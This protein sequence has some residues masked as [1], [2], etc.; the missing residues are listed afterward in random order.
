M[1]TRVFKSLLLGVFYF[2]ASAF[3]YSQLFGAFFVETESPYAR[4]R[5]SRDDVNAQ[6]GWG[7]AVE[8]S[9]RDV[10]ADRR[11][12]RTDAQAFDSSGV[13]DNPYMREEATPLRGRV[14]TFRAASDASSSD[15]RREPDPLRR[16]ERG[17]Q[18]Y[19]P[20]IAKIVGRSGLKTVEDGSQTVP[21]YYGT[22][23]YVAEYNS[24][25]I[26][27]TNWHVVNEAEE[28]IDVVFPSGA[29]PS[30]VIFRDETWDLAALIIPLPSD[31][32]PIPISFEGPAIG[33]TFWVG[34]YG[35]SSGL[36]EFQIRSGKLTNYVSLVD[37]A[38]EIVAELN[39]DVEIDPDDPYKLTEAP[40]KILS[41]QEAARIAQMNPTA[42]YETLS[43]DQGVRQGDSGGPIL[44]RYGELSGTLWGSDGKCTM[45]T[46]CVRVRAFLTEAIRCA[47][48]LYAQE[49]LDSSNKESS[50]SFFSTFI[51]PISCDASKRSQ[52]SAREALVAEGTFPISRRL[53]Y[54]AAADEEAEFFLRYTRESDAIKRAEFNADRYYAKNSSD[55]PPSPAIFS[56][57]FVAW[58]RMEK[59]ARPERIEP[60]TFRELNAYSLSELK[61]ERE[62][63][64]LRDSRELW[65]ARDDG[66]HRRLAIQTQGAEE[67]L[68]LSLNELSEWTPQSTPVSYETIRDAQEELTPNLSSS[69]VESIESSAKEA[70][71]EKETQR[72]DEQEPSEPVVQVEPSFESSEDAELVDESTQE[73]NPQTRLSDLTT[74]VVV[75][76]F[77]I[78][79]FF[80]MRL[81]ESGT[82]REGDKKRNK[83]RLRQ[84][85]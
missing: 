4:A 70:E 74:Y 49:Q 6:A 47:S 14:A 52:L 82:K 67:D 2:L 30:R 80:A 48:R 43:I 69:S 13:I 46:P 1:Y 37:P 59:R 35:H 40:S 18:R 83:S 41:E 3:T 16:D 50:L 17:V 61:K 65:A 15:A 77:F 10:S 60:T 75:V 21:F 24:W 20:S 71:T 29:Y 33:E 9:A 19:F 31:L 8:S 38:D 42:L 84:E 57:T 27:V 76:L 51:P 68:T 25:G 85:K 54:R 56:P 79:F 64:A 11:G 32:S 72:A 81:L 23:A 73:D 58:Q 63:R 34:G 7:V 66:S 55:L 78:I 5:Y 26:V 22:G 62:L 39:A 28:S 36:N 12:S 53:V 44:N 45:G